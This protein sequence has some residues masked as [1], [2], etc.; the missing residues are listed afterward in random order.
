MSKRDLIIEKSMEILSERTIS[1]TSIQDITAACGISKGAFYLS[2]KSKEELLIAIFE[3][4]IRDITAKYQ[5]LLN[6]QAEPREKLIQYFVISFQFVEKNYPF[7]MAHGRELINI[8]DP[9][10]L[11][12]II[13]QFKRADYVALF[14][15]DEVYGN[16]ISQ[17]KYDLVVCIQGLVKSYTEIIMNP[18]Q[19]VDYY[20]MSKILAHHIDVLATAPIEPL[21]T[22]EM[23]E[24]NHKKSRH[25]EKEELLSEIEKCKKD[26]LDD[27]VLQDTFDLLT[28]ELQKESPR[29]ALLLG[30][31]SNLTSSNELRWLATLIKQY[32]HHMY[33]KSRTN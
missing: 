5:V 18:K 26:I 9:N 6:L 4:I 15:L 28:E 1:S 31:S 8:I 14:L 16:Q 24:L 27:A 13:Q 20:E 22:K 19:R 25:L 2:F 23:F 21:I 30:M 33:E 29:K 11:E 10:A 17:N 12:E 32:S 3:Y 7:L